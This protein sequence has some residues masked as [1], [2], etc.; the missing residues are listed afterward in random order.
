MEGTQGDLIV[1]QEIFPLIIMEYSNNYPV[2][3]EK[4]DTLPFFG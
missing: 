1:V 2:T 4:L 3:T